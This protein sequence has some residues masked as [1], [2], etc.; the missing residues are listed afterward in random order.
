MAQLQGFA[1][2]HVYGAAVRG[3]AA[4]IPAARLAA[5]RNDSRVALV[6]AERV[7]ELEVQELPTGIDRI[8]VDRNPNANGVK[9]DLDVA[10]IDGGIDGDHPDLNVAGGTNFSGGPSSNWGDGN[11]HGTHVAGTVGA[12]DDV[13]GVVGVAPG[14]K[15]WAVK[16][17]K[18]GGICFTGDMIAGID[19]VADRKRDYNNSVPGGIDFAVANMS[20][21]TSDDKNACT[22]SSGAVH[23]AICGLVDVGVVFA[24]AAGNDGR[25]KDA[26][27][28]VLAVSALADFDGKPGGFG[29]P[30]CRSDQDESL[31]NFSNY[32]PEV[33]I[34]APGVCIF[35][36]W[37]DGGYNTISG[38]SMAS[39]HVAGAVALYLDANRLSPATDAAGVDAIEAAITGAA[40][41]Q[42]ASCGY[43]NE[44]AGQGSDEPL[45]FW[46]AAAIQQ[47]TYRVVHLHL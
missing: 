4:T 38:T 10:I 20:I 24:L 41:P 7:F 25:A 9:V 19:W 13:N 46:L 23:Q 3:F 45:L 33:D 30:T 26:Y 21:S 14:A 8:E 43:T 42:G 29:S 17:C 6:E 15:L 2:R 28:E 37:K 40:L 22:G 12:I 18:N 27:P 47:S 11:G 39:P 1:V 34:A 16:V 36:T 44:R 35:S 32:G 31:A 5:V